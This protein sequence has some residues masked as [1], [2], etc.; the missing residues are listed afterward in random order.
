M[1]FSLDLGQVSKFNLRRIL[2]PS[3]IRRPRGWIIPGPYQR[4][5]SMADVREQNERIGANLHMARPTKFEADMPER[6]ERLARAGNSMKLIAKALCV[7]RTTLENWTQQRGELKE[8]IERGRLHYLSELTEESLCKRIRG[9]FYVERVEE[10]RSVKELDPT[11]GRIE[12]V[13]KPV[14]VRIAHKHMPPDTRA[15]IF[16]A[17]CVMPEKYK[18]RQGAEAS[19]VAEFLAELEEARERARPTGSS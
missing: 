2:L 16:V 19:G 13:E 6:A 11:T 7:H 3:Q 1:F 17:K 4:G 12:T 8:A 5:W 14:V 15:I 18:E 9:Y 10:L